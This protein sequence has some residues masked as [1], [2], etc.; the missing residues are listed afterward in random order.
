MNGIQSSSSDGGVATSVVEERDGA[1]VVDVVIGDGL[2]CVGATDWVRLSDDVNMRAKPRL[3]EDTSVSES[4]GDLAEV[5]RR[6]KEI[7]SQKRN[8]IRWNMS[9]RTA[10][11]AIEAIAPPGSKSRKPAK[12]RRRKRHKRLL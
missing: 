1:A 3:G 10:E 9:T 7:Q 5:Q 4:S 11:M 2:T 12:Q 8:R 6:L